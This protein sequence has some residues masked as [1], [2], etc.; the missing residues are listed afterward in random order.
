M[1]PSA[2]RV[3]SEP[4]GQ[5]SVL[6]LSLDLIV[7]S[8]WSIVPRCFY[9]CFLITMAWGVII[10]WSRAMHTARIM[11]LIMM[12]RRGSM[13]TMYGL[14]LN[15]LGSS[16]LIIG[17]PELLFVY[18]DGIENSSRHSGWPRTLLGLISLFTFPFFYIGTP[19]FKQAGSLVMI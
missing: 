19:V 14:A 13:R 15:K 8:Q 9:G 16:N 18:H 4:G 11:A 2:P 3:C 7:T 1:C 5:K 12:Q 6:S 10:N 17:E